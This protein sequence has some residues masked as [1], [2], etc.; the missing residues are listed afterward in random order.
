MSDNQ[1]FN[2]EMAALVMF[3]YFIGKQAPIKQDE[4]QSLD[5]LVMSAQKMTGALQEIHNGE[6]EEC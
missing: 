6:S 4:P 5:M 3:A 2:A 1:S